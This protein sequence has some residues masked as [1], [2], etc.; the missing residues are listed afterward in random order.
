[1]EEKG[2]FEQRPE[3]K[4]AD[5]IPLPKA[6]PSPVLK[7]LCVVFALIAIGACGYIVYD[8]VNSGKKDDGK[9]EILTP[10]EKKEL[11]DTEVD[12]ETRTIVMDIY[13]GMNDFFEGATDFRTY[14]SFD[15]GVPYEFEDGYAT[16]I[17]KSYEAW[18]ISNSYNADF[19]A[20]QGKDNYISMIDKIMK[21]HNLKRTEVSEGLFFGDG[22]L[23]YMNDDGFVCVASTSSMPG[24][25][26]C[27]NTKWLSE[28][29]KEFVKDL[30]DA[31]KK[32]ADWMKDDEETVY[33]YANENKIRDGGTEPYQI[34]EGGVLDAAIIFYR[35]GED[36]EWKFFTIT[37]QALS[38]G[39]YNTDELR[40]AFKGDSCYDESFNN[41]IV[42]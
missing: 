18:Y 7:V 40:A 6:K 22:D 30:I 42:K 2:E 32:G 13:K 39:D 38:C 23:Y 20:G 28:T 12:E 31:Y 24:T 29:R 26:S 15:S 33:L 17:V 16:S 25:V 10:P 4:P 34:I 14:L 37:Q 9:P 11:T 35:K 36:S 19:Y 41:S 1:M 5:S 21:N 8:K 27:S 3:V